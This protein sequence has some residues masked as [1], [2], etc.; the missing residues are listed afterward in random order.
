MSGPSSRR[1][2]ITIITRQ[3]PI[4]R[5]PT[6]YMIHADLSDRAGRLARAIMDPPAHR[7]HVRVARLPFFTY[8]IYSAI[9]RTN[10]PR[11][12]PQRRPANCHAANSGAR[13]RRGS[14][15]VPRSLRPRLP[16]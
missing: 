13:S 7:G 12:Q 15:P 6:N 3:D 1:H 8:G 9:A 14:C 4:G 16:T 10:I 11:G 5:G 2:P